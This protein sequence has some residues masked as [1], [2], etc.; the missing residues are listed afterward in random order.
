MTKQWKMT[1]SQMQEIRRGILLAQHDA[2]VVSVRIKYEDDPS[3]IVNDWLEVY[4]AAEKLIMGE[5]NLTNL[6][7]KAYNRRMDTIPLS[8]YNN[9]NK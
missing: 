1:E 5:F 8:K 7:M 2:K 9:N 4:D 3:G 6:T